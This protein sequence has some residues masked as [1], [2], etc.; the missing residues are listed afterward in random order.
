MKEYIKG[1]NPYMPLWEHVPDGEPRVFEYNGEK[2]V[3]VYGSH[4]TLK[5]EYCG[6]DQV[7]WSAPV[8][9]LTNWKCHGVCYTSDDNG[10]LY[11]PDV[12]QKGDTFYMYAAEGRGSRIMVASSKNPAGP[13]TNPVKTEL[14][15]DPGIL[16]DDDGRV[17]AYWGFCKQF[18]AELNDDMA[19]IKKETL[20]E[21]VIL[22][23]NAQWAPKDGQLDPNDAFFEAS[24]PRKVNGKYVYIYSKRYYTNQPQYGVYEECNGFLSYKYSDTPL[25][26]YKMGGDISLNGGELMPNGD[27]TMSMSYRWGNNHGSIINV[28]GQWYVFYHR[29]TGTDEFARQGMVEPVD[30]AVDKNGKVFIGKITYKDG[31]PVASEPVE[32]TSQGAHLNGLDARKIISAGYAC[33]IYGGAKGGPN[34]GMGGAYIKPVYEQ[35]DTVSAPIVDITSNLSVGFRYLQ[36]GTA[37]AKTVTAEITALE[38]LTV[39]VHVDDYKGKVVACFNM[40]KGDKTATAE[41]TSG[42]VG[43]R[44]VYFEFLSESKNVIAEFSTFTFD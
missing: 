21:N 26:D 9:D 13:F 7:V 33:H 34:G 14:G 30:V 31:E 2:R 24:S 5:T 39:K 17:Y 25:G 35:T 29:Q 16:V 36:F 4:D 10:V 38:D 40:K 42:L 8:S 41:I 11:A 32:M 1:A 15:F 3:Y 12:V 18:M 43:K 22:H 6:P 37:S 20:R 23:C 27:G 44:A 28:E 19:T